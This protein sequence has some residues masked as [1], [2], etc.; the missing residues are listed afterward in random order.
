MKPT[1]VFVHGPNPASRTGGGER[2]V[3]A[4]ARAAMRAGFESHVFCVADRAGIEECELGTLHRVWSPARPFRTLL[5]PC[6][7]PFLA[8][9]LRR[10]LAGR[11]GPHVIH[12]FTAHAAIAA[13]ASAWSVRQG[14]S[15]AAVVSVWDGL[16]EESL[17]KLAGVEP[18]QGLR[19]RINPAIEVAWNAVVM[20]GY[21]GRGYR[22][23]Q[24]VYVNYESVRRLLVSGYGVD[25]ARIHTL[26]YAP[27]TAFLPIADRPTPDTVAE[28]R[29]AG[30]PLI[31]VISRHVPRKGLAIL[32]GALADLLAQGCAFRACFVGGGYLLDHHRQLVKD[33]GLSQVVR[34]V[35]HAPESFDYLRHADL[36]VLPSLAEGSGSLSLIEAMQAGVAVIATR[37]DGIPE[38][39][40]DGEDAL[41]VEPGNVR[42]LAEALRRLLE[43]PALRRHLG[44][45]GHETFLRR[46]SA[47]ALTRG[48]VEAYGQIGLRA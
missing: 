10:F 14:I 1:V 11:Q 15:S 5:A 17:A 25:P 16:Y 40:T 12:A 46:F 41:L 42:E 37:I 8:G 28:L 34:V 23:C 35:G 29:S 31:V 21:E 44:A 19:G 32:L 48:M 39:V 26:P 18:S 43:D 45:K 22:H 2:Y 9:G 20:R 33:L 27:E 24:A 36:F 6:H 3:C 13:N 7:A 4:Q 30:V 47:D 38:D